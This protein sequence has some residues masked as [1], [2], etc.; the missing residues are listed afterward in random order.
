[1]LGGASLRGAG[2]QQDVS[3]AGRDKEGRIGLSRNFFFEKL[4]QDD[5]PREE[6]A[7]ASTLLP[8]PPGARS[9]SP[10]RQAQG[11]AHVF[12]EWLKVGGS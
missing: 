10:R 9:L 4:K 6:E 1:M 12:P 5:K 7:P 11:A 8:L 2:A 3:S